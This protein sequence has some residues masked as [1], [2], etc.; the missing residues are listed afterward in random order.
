MNI[1][2]DNLVI[3]TTILNTY[4]CEINKLKNNY[5]VFTIKVM[6]KQNKCEVEVILWNHMLT[7]YMTQIW[8]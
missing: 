5:M 2:K 8:I 3:V 6:K 7:N 1:S 4:I